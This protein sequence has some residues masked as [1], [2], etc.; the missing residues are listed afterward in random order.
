MKLLR[1]FD[2]R[3]GKFDNPPLIRK[4]RGA[5][6]NVWLA[7]ASADEIVALIQQVR[8][9]DFVKSTIGASDNNTIRMI[10]KI[11]G[12]TRTILYEHRWENS[13]IHPYA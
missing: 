10:R 9:R 1:G 4:Y 8:R 5:V 12:N 13:R 2:E 6:Q 3:T 11:H 7:I